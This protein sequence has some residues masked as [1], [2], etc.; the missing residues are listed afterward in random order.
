[1]FLSLYIR[2]LFDYLSLTHVCPSLQIETITDEYTAVFKKLKQAVGNSTASD[3]AASSHADA[4]LTVELVD[5]M[6]VYS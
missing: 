2:P 4:R 6:A 5:M 3:A 1:L